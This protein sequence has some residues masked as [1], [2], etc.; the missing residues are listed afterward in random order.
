M[1]CKIPW[2]R[3]GARDDEKLKDL[4][5]A[6]PFRLCPSGVHVGGTIGPAERSD[7]S[8]WLGLELSGVRSYSNLKLTHLIVIR[9][10]SS[11]TRRDTLRRVLHP[12]WQRPDSHA[13]SSAFNRTMEDVGWG[14]NRMILRP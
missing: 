10:H 5:D 4:W 3:C 13:N 7:S 12:R 14:F 2:T 6:E 1:I 11:R 9:V 8:G